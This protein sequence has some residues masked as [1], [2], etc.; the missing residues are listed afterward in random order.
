[1]YEEIAP[2]RTGAFWSVF[3]IIIF[4]F[5]LLS[6]PSWL[7]GFLPIFDLPFVKAIFEFLVFF[8]VC[9]LV[10]KF[11]R[12]YAVETRYVLS[13]AV[14]TVYEKT[15]KREIVSAEI[16]LSGSTELIPYPEAK[17]I[18]RER[19]IKETGIVFG[20]ADKKE[21]YVLFYPEKNGKNTLIFQPSAKFVEILKQL[22]LDKPEKI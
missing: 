11:L 16:D 7:E 13:D 12:T 2:R 20:V 9:L 1:M 17:T 15:G 14:L 19:G 10:L 21:A 8:S 18:L 4:G 6:L 3:L 22:G 5:I